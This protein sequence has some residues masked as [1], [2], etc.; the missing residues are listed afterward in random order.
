MTCIACKKGSTLPGKVTVTIDKG[1][2]VV[3]IRDVPA[4]VCSTC[5]EEY[6]DADTMR[7]LEKLVCAAQKAGLNIAIQH[8]KAA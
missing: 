4:H 1:A 7:D 2:T 8:F 5:G 3:V 6:I